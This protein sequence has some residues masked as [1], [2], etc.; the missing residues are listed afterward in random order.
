M[1]EHAQSTLDSCIKVSAGPSASSSSTI[2]EPW[3]GT[4]TATSFLH[5]GQF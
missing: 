1:G 3:G 4:S 2:L 5:F